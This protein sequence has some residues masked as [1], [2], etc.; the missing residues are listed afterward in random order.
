MNIQIIKGLT[1]NLVYPLQTTKKAIVKEIA[2][3]V[4]VVELEEII[5]KMC[6]D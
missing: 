2:E 3:A 4:A 6:Y 5:S 1:T